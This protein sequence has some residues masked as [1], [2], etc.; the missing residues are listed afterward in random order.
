[1]RGTS[2]CGIK[3]AIKLELI[4]DE[5]LRRLCRSTLRRLSRRE[6]RG[7]DVG[8]GCEDCETEA[9]SVIDR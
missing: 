7:D 5:A 4:D 2:S 1:M 9:G 6:V 8:E 3:G